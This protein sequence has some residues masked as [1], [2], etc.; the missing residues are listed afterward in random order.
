MD[1]KLEQPVSPNQIGEVLPA[2]EV[3]QMTLERAAKYVMG[4]K[5]TYESQREKFVEELAKWDRA[6]RV[7]LE[8]DRA[9][10][11]ISD[12]AAP[13]IHDNSEA[14]ISRLKEAI[15]PV[16][17]DLVELDVDDNNRQLAEYRTKE[18][19]DQ[20]DKQDIRR[21]VDTATRIVTK[22][23]T[24]IIKVPMVNSQ[25][26]VLTRQIVQKQIDTPIIDDNNQPI[27]DP[28]TGQ[29]M[30]HS[31]VV[32]S[33]EIKP[34]M[35][36]QYF[37]PGYQV[38]D[39]LEDIYVDPLIENIQDQPIVIHRI[40][41]TWPQLM[42]LVEKKVLF[43]EQVEK[44]KGKS[45][46]TTFGWSQ[47]RKLE[48]SGMGESTEQDG[49]P[50]LY[51]LFEAYCDFSIPAKDEEGKEVERIYPC[52]ISVIGNTT[53]GLGPN[54]YF[55]QQ[56]PYLK[57][58]YRRIEG[59]FYGEGAIQPVLYLFHEYCDTM[60]QINDS[61]VL[62]LNPIK[63]QRAG[64]LA[65]KQDLDIEPGTTWYEQQSGDIRFASFDYSPVANGL[66][67]LELLEQRI[68]RGMGISPL[69]LGQG[70]SMDLDKT[71][72]G[73]QKIIAQSDKKFKSIALDLEDVFI[74]GWAEM[75]YKHNLQFNPI[76]G[77]DGSFQQING[78]LGFEV[79]G[80]ESFFQKQEKILNMQMFTQGVANVPGMNIAGLVNESAHLLGIEIDE[81]KYGP[82]YTPP[83]PPPPES[84]PMN[85]SVTIPLDPSKGTWMAMAAADLLNKKEGLQ[86]DLDAIGQAGSMITYTTPKEAKA[87]SGI[88]PPQKDS[89]SKSDSRTKK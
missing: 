11:G 76:I 20:L 60:N 34:E 41:V 31:E 35:D 68:N 3:D 66:Q 54:P 86:L 67:Y 88:M 51:E 62:A 71:W 53:V 63:I 89:Y 4:S 83:L 74:R 9:Y 78:E 80:V 75:A 37:G 81:A 14:V 48:N 50:K 6:Y 30:V 64:S 2:F 47:D 61:K 84:K 18:L 87:E 5:T 82:L 55:M 1:N 39:N 42:E 29:P 56:K 72:R 36:L 49:R 70:D 59:E 26:V 73:T 23:G 27:I 52:K 12:K 44:V 43:K 10:Q 85:M 46:Q 40:L 28:Q 13:I 65:S 38:I 32:Q 77:M 57:A 79:K 8:E 33:V 58:T 69:I 15:L 45:Y 25:R 24:V 16:D 22:F 17:D 7:A 19:N 21:K